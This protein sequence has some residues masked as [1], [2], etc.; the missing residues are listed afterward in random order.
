MTRTAAIL[1]A[2]LMLA[3]GCGGDDDDPPAEGASGASGVASP[4]ITVG[5]FI[6]ELRPDKQT[7]LESIVAETPACKGVEVDSGFVLLVSAEAIDAGQE[8]PLAELVEE[9]C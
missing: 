4:A 9:Q 7:I 2:A 1:A 5:E 6:A 8:S 3:A